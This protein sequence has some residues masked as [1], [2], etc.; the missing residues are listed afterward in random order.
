MPVGRL[1][2][3]RARL[4]AVSNANEQRLGPS[5]YERVL[6]WSVCGTRLW[7]HENLNDETHRRLDRL[8]GGTTWDSLRWLITTGHAGNVAG[9][10]PSTTNL[11]TPENI[12]R[13]KG[14]PILFL[15]GSQNKVFAPENTDT[16]YTT[17]CNAHGRRW[18]QREVLSGRGHLDAW[19]GATA[20][21]DVY[22]RVLQHIREAEAWEH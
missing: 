20:H 4:W 8:L 1:P 16:S 18:Y 14:I 6:T 10:L 17:L 5:S 12:E 2:Q 7:T 13:L 21:M 22:P 3:V 11:V 15:S 9:N 19:I